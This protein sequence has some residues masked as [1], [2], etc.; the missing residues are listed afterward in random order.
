MKTIRAS[1]IGE[2][3]YCR[4][5]WWYRQQGHE[6]KNRAALE[7]GT[8]YHQRHGSRVFLAGALR[9]IGF[10]VVLAALVMFFLWGTP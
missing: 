5:A 8:A 2:F 4:R 10:L 9:L 1:E 6:P 3:L 7:K